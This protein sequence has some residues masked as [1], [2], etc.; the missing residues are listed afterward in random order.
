MQSTSTSYSSFLSPLSVLIY[1]LIIFAWLAENL[2]KTKRKVQKPRHLTNWPW[3]MCVRA[4]AFFW[5][6]QKSWFEAQ[7]SWAC[8]FVM[9]VLWEMDH[10]LQE[11]AVWEVSK[12]PSYL[13]CLSRNWLYDLLRGGVVEEI[14]EATSVKVGSPIC[15]LLSVIDFLFGDSNL[16]PFKN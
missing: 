9:H 3:L 7:H 10:G 2:T 8:I 14:G 1:L 6:L 15:C 11:D 16:T 12:S 13:K 5:F 4:S